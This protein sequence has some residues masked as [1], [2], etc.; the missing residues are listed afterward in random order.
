M[1]GPF[2]FTNALGGP[3]ALTGAERFPYDDPAGD[4]Q[5]ST[6]DGL[7]AFLLASTGQYSSNAATTSFTA[8]TGEVSGGQLSVLD[9]PGMLGAGANV[10]TPAAAAL[11]AA[12]GDTRWV[13]R[14]LNNSAGAFAWTLLAGVGVTVTGTATVAQATW[15]E[16]LATFTSPTALVLQNVGAG[17]V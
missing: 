11:F 4:A 2:F 3:V 6:A 14:V 15:R 1:T 8:S 12:V 10:T 9:L 16:W 5:A 17:D 13:L 7:K